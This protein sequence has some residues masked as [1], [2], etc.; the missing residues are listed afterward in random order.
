MKRTLR[1]VLLLA[2]VFLLAGCIT[3][4]EPIENSQSTKPFEETTTSNE[5]TEPT[6]EETPDEGDDPRPHDLFIHMI[7]VG[8]GDSLFIELPNGETMLIDAGVRDAGDTV[9]DYL[10]ALEVTTIDY[11]IG[12]HPDA[13]H[14]GGL[15][16]VIPAF[17]IRNIYLPDKPHNTQLFKELLETIEHSDLEIDIGEAG[18]TIVDTVIGDLPL[19]V[20]II[21]PH[22]ERVEGYDNNNASIVLRIT[23]GDK[24]FL[25][26][27]DAEG[28]VEADLLNDGIDLQADVLKV[29]HHGSRTSTTEAFLQA[30]KPSIALISAGEGNQYGHPHQEV[31]NRLTDRGIQIFRTD[32]LGTVIVSSNG[33]AIFVNDDEL[34]DPGPKEP[35]TL[36]INEVMPHPESG[37][38]WIELYNPNDES[39]PIGKYFIL[40]EAENRIEIERGVVIPAQGFYV[41]Y[42]N[43]VILNNDRDTVYLYDVW[44]QLLD[45][46]SYTKTEKGKSFYRLPDGGDWADQPGI[47][48]PGQP[49]AGNPLS[50]TTEVVS[51]LM[52][53]IVGSG[54]TRKNGSEG[55]T[56]WK[57]QSPIAPSMPCRFLHGYCW[58]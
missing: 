29:G 32:E 16:K 57:L 31:L 18:V 49:N 5:V 56:L 36:Y 9:I 30:V 11:V 52:Y 47:P 38:E 7:D 58:S 37:E 17:A 50:G 46:F 24:R 2:L 48:T 54:E 25:F 27:G 55:R 22:P 1:Y 20:E 21:S 39:I 4:I 40:D 15:V 33:Y 51:F 8:Q 3:F 45:Q 14:I 34:S 12:T 42:L 41:L 44:G 19:K 26:M 23:Y 13:D 43:R 35:V 10:H 28:P 53:E 6:E